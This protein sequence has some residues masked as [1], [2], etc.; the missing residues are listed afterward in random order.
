MSSHSILSFSI[1][2]WELT[3][4]RIIS[5]GKFGSFP[6]NL[7]L[8]RP[9][10]LT[11]DILD[12]GDGLSHTDLRIVS[13]SD[14][15]AEA[16]LDDHD[17]PP[18]SR[19]ELNVE[20]IDGVECNARDDGTVSIRS[21]RNTIDDPNR[22]ALSF[23]EIEELKRLSTGK[24]IVQRLMQSH[25]G[26]D[27]K[28]AFSLV[29][30]AIRKRGKYLKR[31]TVLP[32]DVS[33]LLEWILTE[34][35]APKIMEL[36]EEMLGLLLCWSNVHYMVPCSNPGDP[37][38]VSSIGRWL[39]VDETGGLLV[40][41]LAE[42][43]DILY[44]TEDLE[45]GVSDDKGGVT[46]DTWLQD[47]SRVASIKGANQQPCQISSDSA[48]SKPWTGDS[49]SHPSV[50][51]PLKRHLHT[52]SAVPNSITLLHS[53]PQPNLALLKYFNF[54][55]T[56]GNGDHPLQE[57]LK[58]LSWLQL[59]SPEED[60]AYQEP[61]VVEEDVRQSWKGGKRS[62]YYRRRR[63]W[64]RVKGAVD[65][66]RR[67]QFD[68]LIIASVMELVGVL[69]HLLPLLKGGAPV[70]IYSPSVESLVELADLFSRARRTAFMTNAPEE[71]EMPNKD[72][73]IDP[74]LLLNTTL[75]TTRARSW[76]VLPG[77]THP[78][79][80]GRGGAEGY[81]F[82]GTRVLKE[83]RAKAR[84]RFNKKRRVDRPSELVNS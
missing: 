64:E 30:Y 1:S 57:H 49:K 59:L 28:T 34:K 37:N 81:V 69:S 76:Q 25:S 3:R 63:R 48:E 60:S 74:T 2:T 72:F 16:I 78:M 14:L 50:H 41:A 40:A 53:A 43:M 12:K 77:R 10:H 79:M 70:V 65:D 67:G 21:N 73:P 18:E 19:D 58:T 22:Q 42:K 32:L 35:D 36:R 83:G 75:Q 15:H 17:T 7:L 8:G 82:T 38:D 23:E 54:D 13:A 56:A 27:E 66:T 20:P 71:G 80:M 9:Y 55:D 61:E 51:H 47:D 29:K 4:I 11:F 33:S 84:G 26:I 44:P 52:Q 39:V 6:A 45:D 24:D 5:I 46:A 31:F 68:G 62:S